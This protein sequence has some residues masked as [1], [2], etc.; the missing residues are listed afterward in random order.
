[1]ADVRRPIAQPT[2]WG[3]LPT[4]PSAL[5]LKLSI[6]KARFS[7]TSGTGAARGVDAGSIC[8]ARS[9]RDGDK[10]GQSRCSRP[11]ARRCGGAVQGSEGGIVERRRSFQTAADAAGFR[12]LTIALL[13]W[14][15][16]T[17]EALAAAG[18][19]WLLEND[20]SAGQFGHALAAGD[21]N[22]DGLSDVVVGARVYPKPY[23]RAGRVLLFPGAAG[24]P[25][26]TPAWR[27]EGAEPEQRFA[28]TV[29]CGD[30]NGD[31]CADVLVGSWMHRNR[32]GALWLFY[33]SQDGPHAE[34]DW[35][36]EGE[37]EGLCLG[38]ALCAAGDLNGD[39]FADAAVG[40]AYYGE[41]DRREGRVYVWYGGPTGLNQKAD[42]GFQSRRKAT[43][44]GAAVAAAGDVNGDGYDDLLVGEPAFYL[45]DRKT[46]YLLATGRMLV[47]HG[48]RQGLAKQPDATFVSPQRMRSAFGR[49]LSSA[50]DV[51]G[52]G[53]ADVL[54]GAYKAEEIYREEGK[55]F[56]FLGSAGGLASVPAWIARGN[57]PDGLFGTSLSAAGDV[58]RDGFADVV[59]GSTWFTSPGANRVRAWLFRGCAQG[60]RTAPDWMVENDLAYAEPG[61]TVQG[62]G[63]LNGDGHADVGMASWLHKSA[64]NREGLVRVFPGTADGL[65]GSMLQADTPHRVVAWWPPPVRAPWWKSPWAAG[66]ATMAVLVGAL[67][68][69]RGLEARRWRWRVRAMEREQA[70]SRERARIAQDMHDHLGASL[71][72]L[73]LLSEL[74][75]RDL[76]WPERARLHADELVAGTREL[77]GTVD[78]IV[79]AL[80]PRK[81]RLENLASYLSAYT[82]EFLRAA[83]LRCRLDLPERLPDLRL[84]TEARHSLFLACKEA[85]NNVTKHARA[86]EVWLR[87]HVTAATLTLAIEDDGCGFA[88]E[89]AGRER[90]GLVNLRHRIE[91]LGGRLTVAS[92]PG[93]GTQVRME[94]PLPA[95]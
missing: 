36:V 83:G 91:S 71:T 62:L 95:N 45:R 72:R 64:L 24:G 35:H 19:T 55:V 79:W 54:V 21:V 86:T 84:R 42:W 10:A 37:W 5:T 12:L 40:A 82:E 63:D 27:A 76:A 75:R 2:V 53:Y 80:N 47:F 8:A 58:D 66:S 34:A 69:L 57:V 11:N 85:L 28:E 23:W 39:G 41:V 56:L 13:V 65:P 1:M 20:A 6:I 9:E 17:A 44:L 67:A 93:R 26:T 59:V 60:L 78:E 88:P 70:L 30:F 81:D 31:G 7:P 33:G 73:T 92:Q 51:N 46:G 14:A 49:T 3:K 25:Q 29:A 74:T 52:D 90:N 61:V 15:G 38:Y 68:L 77:A 50:G 43:S 94:V 16:V 87:L 48:H 18:A 4:R 22:G 89:S 32:R